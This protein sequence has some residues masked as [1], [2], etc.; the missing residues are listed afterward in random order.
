MFF[1]SMEWQ[2]HVSQLY[3]QT[4]QNDRMH[5]YNRYQHHD[6]NF[7]STNSALCT[8][9]WYHPHYMTLV[10]VSLH[11]FERF[12]GIEDYKLTGKVYEHWKVICCWLTV[13]CG[14]STESTECGDVCCWPKRKKKTKNNK[15]KRQ[16]GQIRSVIRELWL[17]HWRREPTWL[18]NLTRC[19]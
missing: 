12:Q 18:A 4:K 3:K 6:S 9:F 14:L 7:A 11:P 1:E 17:G 10:S 8:A 16:I 5:T 15:A 2:S 19:L 13:P